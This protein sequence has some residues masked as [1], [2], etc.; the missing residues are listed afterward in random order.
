AWLA[1]FV[2]AVV[3]DSLRG[4][5]DLTDPSLAPLPGVGIGVG[6]GAGV[7]VGLAV[8]ALAQP[9]SSSTRAAS[10]PPT[11]AMRVVN[12]DQPLVWHGEPPG[13]DRAAVVVAGIA[14]VGLSLLAW[15]VSW[16]LLPMAALVVRLDLA[17]ARVRT[18]AD[19]RTF[20][21]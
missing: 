20:T 4:Q 9:D 2:T 18:F 15:A 14:G 7:V 1:V 8:A 19:A 6:F 5:L 3:A 13:L 12:D 10:A 17:G 21:L 11:S 16:W